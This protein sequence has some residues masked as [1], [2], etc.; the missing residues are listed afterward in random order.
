VGKKNEIFLQIVH[1]FVEIYHIRNV[2]ST[3]PTTQPPT[4]GGAM[5][6][7]EDISRELGDD[8]SNWVGFCGLLDRA[9]YRLDKGR[10]VNRYLFNDGSAILTTEVGWGIEGRRPFSWKGLD[11]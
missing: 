11:D 3:H 4:E 2:S 10:Y 8:G 1:F 5:T 7:A 6:I 9:G